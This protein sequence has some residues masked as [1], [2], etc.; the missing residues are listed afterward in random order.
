MI[1][2]IKYPNKSEALH[3]ITNDIANQLGYSSVDELAE[4]YNGY[5]SSIMKEFIEFNKDFFKTEQDIHEFAKNFRDEK[6]RVKRGIALLSRKTIIQSKG[7]ASKGNS[8]F[9]GSVFHTGHILGHMLVSNIDNFNSRKGNYE[10]IFPQT[11]WSNGGGRD[12]ASFTLNSYRGNSQLTY[13]R[14]VW[15]KIN[16]KGNEELQVYYQVDLIYNETEEVP[17][18]I[19][20]Q[21]IPSDGNT[22]LNENSVSLNIFIPNIR[23]NEITE[24]DY[25]FWNSE[26]NR[27]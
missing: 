26:V 14:R 18:G 9:S 13:E 2:T 10:N 5:G 3:Y 23:Y 1:K 20:I 25:S 11:S 4:Y 16:K 7:G 17:R 12:F 27:A 19:H 15:N 24:L 22:K 8:Q 6:G 21:A